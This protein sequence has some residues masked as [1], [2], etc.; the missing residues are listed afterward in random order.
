MAFPGSQCCL[1]WQLCGLGPVCDQVA[2]GPTVNRIKNTV[3]SDVEV[4]VLWETVFMLTDRDTGIYENYIMSLFPLLLSNVQ[5][6]LLLL[7][8]P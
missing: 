3:I 2:L 5:H 7:S 1:P 4:S 8:V 6:P